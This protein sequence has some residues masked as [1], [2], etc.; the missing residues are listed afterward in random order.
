[1]ALRLLPLLAQ[2][3]ESI[4]VRGRDL[5][6][7]LGARQL[8]RRPLRYTR[9]SLLLMLAMSMGVFA[10][11]YASTW[12]NSQRDQ[13]E[14]QIGSD[15]RLAP[16]RGP[17]A[18]PAWALSSAFASV[19]GVHESM[20]VERQRIQVRRGAD[21]GELLA[22]DT[23][24]V[25][26]VVSIRPDLSRRSLGETVG[27]LIDERPQ[28]AVVP[29]DGAPQRLLV[30]VTVALDRIGQFIFDPFTGEQFVSLSRRFAD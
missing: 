30:G 22:L 17:S 20:P 2:A 12:T 19:D 24:V 14:F 3:A 21:A 29:V 8:A 4:V 25:A 10:V 26:Q 15:L 11:S 23:E 6:G 16:A 18:L 1:V 5:V 9:A 7:S 13:A 27:P 28:I